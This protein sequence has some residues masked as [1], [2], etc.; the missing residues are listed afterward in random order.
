MS[1]SMPRAACTY[2]NSAASVFARS[3]RMVIT[4]LAGDRH[5]GFRGEGGPA[6]QAELSFP[7]GITLDAA[8]NLYFAD[9]SNHRV[10]RISAGVITIVLGTESQAPIFRPNS[11]HP[12]AWRSTPR[13]TFTW[14]TQAISAP[15][16]SARRAL[17]PLWRQTAVISLSIRPETS[18]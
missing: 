2:P 11:I 13:A 1:C 8:G 16:Y 3:L 4:T 7:A 9:S 14:R 5:V 17:S 10:R 6:F 12:R 15:R 18:T